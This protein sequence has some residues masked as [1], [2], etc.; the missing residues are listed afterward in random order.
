MLLVIEAAVEAQAVVA[1]FRIGVV[2]SLEELQLA[3]SRFVPKKKIQR[4]S[5]GTLMLLR[6]SHQFAVADDFHSDVGTSA[7]LVAS[8]N[9]V[10]EH[11]L[12]RVPADHVTAV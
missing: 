1:V 4:Q 9:D 3:D 8:S 12:A 2:E 10:A 5:D 11:A 6:Y 7:R